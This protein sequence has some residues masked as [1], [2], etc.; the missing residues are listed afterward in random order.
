M[1]AEGTVGGTFLL[2]LGKENFEENSVKRF[3]LTTFVATKAQQRHKL[4]LTI[5]LELF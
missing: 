4:T 1:T 3:I 2:E 5:Y